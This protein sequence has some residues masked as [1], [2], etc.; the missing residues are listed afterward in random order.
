MRWIEEPNKRFPKSPEHVLLLDK[1]EPLA[2]AW[3]E[4]WKRIL[5]AGNGLQR[6]SRFSLSIEVYA[7]T[8]EADTG[9]T[10]AKFYN[11]LNRQ[12]DEIG[13]FVI[14][15]DP[16]F[17]ILQDN[18]EDDT[19]FER[20]RLVW[21]LEQYKQLKAVLRSSEIWP[22]YE[23]ISSS[24]PLSIRLA[25]INGWFD[26]A[27]EKDRFGDLPL[28]DQELLAGM[29]RRAHDPMA[30]LTAGILSAPSTSAIEELTAALIQYTPPNFKNI[31]CTIK[32]G[33]EQGRR[34]LFYQ[35]ECPEYPNDG[36]SV[37]NDR[38][39][40]AAT[41]L[42]QQMAPQPGTFEGV[43]IRLSVRPDGSWQRSVESVGQ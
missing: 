19:V 28:E 5:T 12:A 32:E 15:S 31:H 40:R 7:R 23:L 14:R 16:H 8:F 35:I 42:V 38:V 37:V 20:R 24:Q 2:P 30:D 10:T 34:A 22:L 1:T 21:L 18:G 29:E 17:T 36:T 3:L 26:L 13:V 27:P 4:Y 11:S 39:H 9:S 6:G 25:T 43:A 33:L 41:L